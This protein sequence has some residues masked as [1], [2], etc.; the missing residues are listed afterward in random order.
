M[1]LLHSSFM[2]IAE[3]DVLASLNA[4]VDPNTDRNFAASKAVRKVAVDASSVT[5]D[6]L[7]AYPARSQHEALRKLVQNK[8]SAL[9]G[10]GKITVNITHKIASHSVQRGV[11]LIPGVKNIIAVASGKGGVGKSTTAVNL[12]LALAAEG[13]RV[14]ML[15]A[16]IYGPSLPMMLG[17][18]GKPE[19]SDGRTM[20][21]LRNQGRQA[22][23]IG[24]M[25]NPDEP[26][27]WRGPM[28]TQAL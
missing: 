2:P 18:S 19:S 20:E 5:V 4:L 13:A 22:I 27:V 6:L 10:I 3:A 11:K 15:D 12:A 25:I 9:P 14:G 26:M 24:F 8:L 23:S 16:D 7:L 17:I 28:V 1:S 21:P